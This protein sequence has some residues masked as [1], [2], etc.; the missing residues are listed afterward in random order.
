MTE[1]YRLGLKPGDLIWWRQTQHGGYGFTQRVPGVFL[2]LMP[3]RVEVE[4]LKRDGTRV[5]RHVQF[6]NIEPRSADES[7]VWER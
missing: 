5:R 1:S 2:R 4:L 3:R 7:I 6:K